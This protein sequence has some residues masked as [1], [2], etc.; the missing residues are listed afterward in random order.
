MQ[1]NT[2]I[3]CTITLLIS[4]ITG[5]ISKKLPWFEN[6]LIPVQ[7]MLIGL[8]IATTEWF[9]TGNFQMAIAVSGIAAG[10]IYDVLHNINIILK[11]A[12]NIENKEMN[13]STKK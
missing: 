2:E 13:E 11:K 10:G 6:Y 12:L 5:R 4:W 3:F 8:C 1:E 9:F 7:N